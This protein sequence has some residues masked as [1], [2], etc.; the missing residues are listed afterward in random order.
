LLATRLAP[1]VAK[2][3]NRAVTSASGSADVIEALG[4]WLELS[5][6]WLASPP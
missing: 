1:F 6:Y 3:G 5:A 2:H 4:F